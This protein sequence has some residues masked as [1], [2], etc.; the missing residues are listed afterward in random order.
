MLSLLALYIPVSQ[1]AATEYSLDPQHTSVVIAWNHFGFSNPTAYIS[2]V[3]G[4]LSFD[5]DNPEKSSVHVTLPVKTIDTHVKA[6]TDE[7]LGK[8]YFDVNTYPEATFQSTRVES[9]GDNKYDVE[10]NL[11]IKGITK[12]VV[13]HATLNKQDMHPMVKKQAI[14]FDAT[15]VIKRSDFKLDK[16]VPAVSDNVTIT[17]STEAYAK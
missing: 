9:K 15:G 4:K 8:E 11:T 10:G 2:D 14:G 16:Y 13:L 7:F 6:L 5:K 17:L 3:S 12:P 1:A